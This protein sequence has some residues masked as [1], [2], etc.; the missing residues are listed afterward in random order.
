MLYV[1]PAI[2]FKV[3]GVHGSS[4]NSLG[5]VEM[6]IF[7][8][9]VHF[10]LGYGLTCFA[11]FALLRGLAFSTSVASM[12]AIA[13]G[14]AE[15]LWWTVSLAKNDFGAC[16][17]LISALAL[18]V[19]ARSQRKFSSG[20]FFLVGILLGTSF[21]AKYT[22]L[23]TAIPVGFA[24][25]F[26]ARDEERRSSRLSWMIAFV[27]GCVL[28]ASGIILRNW[29]GTGDPIFPVGPS[30]RHNLEILGP[31]YL[32][33]YIGD[34]ADSHVSIHTIFFRVLQLLKEHVLIWC[35]VLLPLSYR[36]LS[37]SA[38]FERM[39]LFI[40]LVLSFSL[41]TWKSGLRAHIRLWGPGLVLCM[42]FVVPV[43]IEALK[44]I[45]IPERWALCVVLVL[46]LA[47]SDLPL[48]SPKTFLQHWPLADALVSHSGSGAK[49]W[50]RG[51]MAPGERATLTGDDGI[52]YVSAFDVTTIP[53]NTVLDSRMYGVQT[54]E[55]GLDIL[56]RNNI[57][58]AIDVRLPNGSSY[59]GLG[60]L[61]A[62]NSQKLAPLVVYKDDTSLIL[63]LNQ[64]VH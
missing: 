39:V 10:F 46:A 44:R 30:S 25:F 37:R 8:Q 55:S 48:H 53:L 35:W 9:W 54:I 43:A 5:L 12:A 22:T 63:D 27:L 14:F 19:V 28:G 15:A 1:W 52:F 59:P 49:A 11:V 50:L 40:C 56:R 6:Q 31:T 38:R 18:F 47:D 17:Y 24:F 23:F 26:L 42:A 60:Q 51:H 57:R 64:G 16:L 2:F 32:F 13:S 4:G 41:F 45:R 7:C 21:T 58:Y 3:A 29:L 62:K 36:D 33:K 20:I 61:I 34:F